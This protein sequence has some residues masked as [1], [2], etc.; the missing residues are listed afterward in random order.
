MTQ[1]GHE[2]VHT[3]EGQLLWYSHSHNPHAGGG[4]LGQRYVDFLAD[5]PPVTVP[6]PILREICQVV[7]E[8]VMGE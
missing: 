7:R 1:W 6:E 2:G 8:M 3:Y 4:A 5:G